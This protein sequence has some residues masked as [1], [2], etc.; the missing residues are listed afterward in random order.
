MVKDVGAATDF[1]FIYTSILH[2]RKIKS[3]EILLINFFDILFLKMEHAHS[4]TMKY[5]LLNNSDINLRFLVSRSNGDSIESRYY[6][7][8]F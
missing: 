7:I 5:N 1:F 6:S 4:D 2:F 8:S 3:F